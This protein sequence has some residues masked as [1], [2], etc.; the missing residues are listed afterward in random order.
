MFRLGHLVEGEWEEYSHP[1]H[2]ERQMTTGNFQRLKVGV[3][4]GDIDVLQ[5]LMLCTEPPFYVLYVL[6]VPRGEGEAGRYQSPLVER[7]EVDAMLDR[8]KIYLR[9]DGRFHLWVHSQTSRAT[10][11]W[12]HH[13]IIYAYGPLD[14]Y[15][16]RLTA[17]G[18][19][20]GPLTIPVPHHHAFRRECD[21]DAEEMLSHFE[22][23][24]SELQSGDD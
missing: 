11:V 9:S 3:P 21:H 10:M 13:N 2:F 19:Q 1:A 4:A 16:K 18:F 8:Y 7:R 22:W 6:I 5:N 23:R 20:N 17:T 14:C 12:D 24:Y 15:E